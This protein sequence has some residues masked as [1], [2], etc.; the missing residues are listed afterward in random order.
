MKRLELF[1][2]RSVEKEVIEILNKNLR[3]SIRPYCCEHAAET[4]PKTAWEHMH[5]RKYF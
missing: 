3:I 4:N 2:N 5:G 1:A